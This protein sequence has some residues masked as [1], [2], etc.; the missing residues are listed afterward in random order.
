MQVVSTIRGWGYGGFGQIPFGGGDTDVQVLLS[1]LPLVIFER[2]STHLEFSAGAL[3][4]IVSGAFVTSSS[5]LI[6]LSGDSEAGFQGAKHTFSGSQNLVIK[7]G[8]TAT[9]PGGQ[10]EVTVGSFADLVGT[11]QAQLTGSLLRLDIA[12]AGPEVITIGAQEFAELFWNDP[13]AL[14]VSKYLIGGGGGIPTTT[15][16]PRRLLDL[17]LSHP[18][19]LTSAKLLALGD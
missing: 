19:A 17:I 11:A 4:N 18:K 6:A 15:G 1:P 8:A 16:D 9:F 7:G 13:R 10:V 14:T 5:G 3:G 12:Y 2:G